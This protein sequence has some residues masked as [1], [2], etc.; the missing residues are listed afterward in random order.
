[1]DGYNNIDTLLERIDSMELYTKDY[2]TINFLL[3]N[4]DKKLFT[5]ILEEV[6]LGNLYWSD[7]E[8]I[9]SDEYKDIIGKSL[10]QQHNL[11]NYIK[12]YVEFRKSLESEYEYNNTT[13]KIVIYDSGADD[14]AFFTQEYKRIRDD[15]LDRLTI[16][17]SSDTAL[18]LAIK[19]RLYN[20]IK[21]GEI[22]LNTGEDNLGSN[23]VVKEDKIVIGSREY[24]YINP[25]DIFLFINS[26]LIPLD[27][28]NQILTEFDKAYM[29]KNG[30]DEK[31]VKH[32]KSLGI[33]LRRKN[34]SPS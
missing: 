34:F 21:N 18:S 29:I 10:E 20:A 15:V 11:S 4:V 27:S 24:E 13:G 14:S 28:D 16:E 12:R 25:E 19:R 22:L 33:L 8:S 5:K 31:T 30:L 1:M 17:K 6:L 9:L 7:F 32:L 3:N 26:Y 23:C 2:D